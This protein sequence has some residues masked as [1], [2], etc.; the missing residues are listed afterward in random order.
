MIDFGEDEEIADDVAA[1]V[2]PLVDTLRRE[3]ERHLAAA[4]SG[5][6]VRCARCA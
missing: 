4:T 6:L 3:L 2:A 5:E 1:G